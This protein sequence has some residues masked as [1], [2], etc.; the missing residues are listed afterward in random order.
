M[1]RFLN[2]Q[3]DDIPEMVE[4]IRGITRECERDGFNIDAAGGRLL[5]AALWREY[6]R[7]VNAAWDANPLN[8]RNQR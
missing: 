8:Y 7:R 3:T 6:Q 4:R 1:K 2:I 5:S